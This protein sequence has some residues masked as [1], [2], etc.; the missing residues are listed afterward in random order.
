MR[1]LVGVALTAIAITGAAAVPANAATAY[2][3]AA[4]T[5]GVSGCF[6]YSYSPG[7]ATT[8]VYYHNRCN[9]EE[10]LMIQWHF[11][12]D[13]IPVPANGKGNKWRTDDVEWVCD[14][15]VASSCS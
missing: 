6:A 9:Y 1:R 10:N 14:A 12:Y 5:R 15:V 13:D 8:T 11:H 4:A 7:D 3:A 2:A